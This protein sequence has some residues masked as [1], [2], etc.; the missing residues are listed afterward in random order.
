MPQLLIHSLGEFREIILG[1]LERADA[2]R[3]VEIGSESGSFSEQLVEWVSARGGSVTAIDPLPDDRVRGLAEAHP[4]TFNL[5]LAYSPEA[6]VGL[7]AADAYLVDGDHNYWV[8]SEE[9]RAI[10]KATEGR[11]PVL[12]MHDVGWPCARR[13]QYYDPAKIPAEHLHPHTYDRGVDVDL[14]MIDG[15][16]RGNGAFAYAE[17]EGGPKNGVLTAV[18]D[19][20]A[21]HPDWELF[22]IPAVFGLGVL[23]PKSHPKRDALVEMLAPLHQNELLRR[24]E[25]NRLRNYLRVIALQDASDAPRSSERPRVP[26][27]RIDVIA[28]DRHRLLREREEL[29]DENATLRRELESLRERL[30]DAQGQWYAKLGATLDSGLRRVVKRK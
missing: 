22:L 1:V 19:F 27:P 29:L 11:M 7:P 16:F 28:S 9:L 24:L 6:L 17:H 20:H 18:E 5:L 2:R 26:S 3:L 10:H 15:G 21:A 14:G 4:Q 23:F 30:T 25:E 8:V 13:D 12:F